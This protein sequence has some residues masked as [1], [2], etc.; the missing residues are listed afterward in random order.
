MTADCYLELADSIDRMQGDALLVR[1]SVPDRGLHRATRMP[2]PF[3]RNRRCHDRTSVGGGDV[4][5]SESEES[6]RL[7][8]RQVPLSR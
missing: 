7:R 8:G 5:V 1:P 2:G 4:M 6:L 3:F